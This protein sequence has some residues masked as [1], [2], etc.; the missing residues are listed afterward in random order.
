VLTVLRNTAIGVTG[1]AVLTWLIWRYLWLP[2]W[3]RATPATAAN[4]LP[5]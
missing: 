3:R 4:P 1:F 5:A 2:L